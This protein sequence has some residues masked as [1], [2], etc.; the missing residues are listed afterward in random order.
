M[1]QPKVIFLDAV[2]TLFGIRGS[3]GQIYGEFARQS[4]VDVD[5]EALDRAFFDSFSASPPCAFP[6]VEPVAIPA[7]E[8]DWWYAI[9]ARSF[10]LIGV[11]D[12]F[13]DFDRFFGPLY[14]HFAKADPWFIYDDVRPALQYWQQQGIEL[15]IVSNFD[16]RLYAVLE[17]LD[18]SRYFT[19]ITISTEANAAKPASQIFTTALS[20]HRCEPTQA[21]HIGDSTGAD[22]EGAKAV[23]IRGILLKR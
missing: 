9:A 3:V 1:S 22:F 12:R 8:Y 11:F 19:S 6:G 15:G 2:N 18:L 5:A 20:K 23:G 13:D 21:W 10:Q 14:L 16:S 7:R 17:A 4:G